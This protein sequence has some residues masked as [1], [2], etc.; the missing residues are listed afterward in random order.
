MDEEKFSVYQFFPDGKWERVREL[1]DVHEAL[2]AA[3]HYITCVGAQVGTTVRVMITD[4]GD[5]CV[6]EWKRGEGVVFPPEETRDHVSK[7]Y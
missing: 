4:N 6:F 5:C 3:S 1:V 2:K 7:G